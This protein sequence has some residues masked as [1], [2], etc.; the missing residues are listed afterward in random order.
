VLEAA[1]SPRRPI[2]P[3]DPIRLSSNEN[4]LGLAPSAR[5]AVIES[6]AWC[7][8]YPGQW[9]R[10][11]VEK[12]ASINGVGADQV[13]MGVGS[14][15]ILQM[16]IQAL[17]SPRAQL[18]IA[19]PTFEDVPRY[20]RT[21]P[22]EL[23]RIPLTKDMA[24][25]LDAMREAAEAQRRPSVVYF[26]NPNNP[27]GTL[28]SA[29]DIDAWIADAP[30]STFFLMDEAYFE[31]ADGAP[32][33]WSALKWVN[34]RPNVLVVRTFSKIHGMAG[35]RL[36]YGIAHPGT[37]SR[38]ADFRAANN[39]PAPAVAAAMAS[40]EDARHAKKSREVN[41]EAKAM[42]H[43]VLDELGLEYLPS[44][45]NFI[46]HRI[47]G[48]LHAYQERMREAGLLVGRD[49][50]PM[51]E[52]NRLSFGLPEEMEVWADAIKGFRAKGWI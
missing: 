5:E 9:A 28:T 18:V 4:P 47:N 38:L 50:P 10:P 22:Y 16:A 30:E 41:D 52:Y 46:M 31:Y 39:T 34:D 1:F 35:M 26:C 24:H 12:I 13:M 32:G 20:R 43:E 29:A 37:I 44:H 51:L 15:E 42:V 8:R 2:A 11:L 17:A 36:G 14:T 48:D 3:G 6:I 25:D 33:Y 49:F 7:N 23:V 21:F 27:T 40:L 45:T 19:D